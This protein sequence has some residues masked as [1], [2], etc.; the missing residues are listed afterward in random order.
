MSKSASALKN[1]P[2]KLKKRIRISGFLSTGVFIEKHQVF[3]NLG[4]NKKLVF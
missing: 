1:V 2:L 3:A 4:Q